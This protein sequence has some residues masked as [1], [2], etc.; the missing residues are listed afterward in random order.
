MHRR[1]LPLFF[2]AAGLG[3]V[4]ASSRAAVVPLGKEN[5][6]RAG[7]GL[8]FSPQVEEET[9]VLQQSLFKRPEISLIEPQTLPRV[10]RAT[11]ARVPAV[12]P[13]AKPPVVIVPPPPPREISLAQRELA[14]QP[15]VETP[16]DRYS[17]SVRTVIARLD[18]RPSGMAR[19]RELMSVAHAFRYRTS[20]DPYR[21]ALPEA[22]ESSR[23][24]DCKA[25][26]LWLYDQ[27]GDPEALYV[28]GKTFKGTKSNHAWIYWHCDSRWWILDPTNRSTPVPADTFPDDR[29]VPYY[30]FGKAGT[31]RHRATALFLANAP[32]AP[33]VATPAKPGVARR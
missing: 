28:I 33:T 24:G 22:T 23:T 8:R 1:S 2:S 16:Y 11:P 10:L 32:A 31:F 4:L 12:P 15:A 13:K 20:Q 6:F 5:P 17:G 3:I 14:L 27:L 18:L 19:A 9:R 21:A 30:S 25:K 29:Y 7:A 26:S